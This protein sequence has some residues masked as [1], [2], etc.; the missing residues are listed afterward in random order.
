M[1]QYIGTDDVQAILWRDVNGSPVKI[2]VGTTQGRSI[3]VTD[4]NTMIDRAES[5]AIGWL[6]PYYVIPPVIGTTS[7]LHPL[8]TEICAKLAAAK[9]IR[10]VV[11]RTADGKPD[12]YADYLETSARDDWKPYA[13]REH[14]LIGTNG[15]IVDFAGGVYAQPAI[16]QPQEGNVFQVKTPND[17]DSNLSEEGFVVGTS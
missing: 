10:T 17:T 9:V 5:N 13:S 15:A 3:S 7:T 1:P 11:Q 2:S 4:A 12:P 8:F 6:A 16:D 14:V